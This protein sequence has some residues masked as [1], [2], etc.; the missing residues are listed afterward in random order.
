MTLISVLDDL[1]S[2]FIWQECEE[3]LDLRLFKNEREFPGGP[4]VRTP[5][6]HC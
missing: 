5:R 4:V 1:L 3:S 2:D 6:F